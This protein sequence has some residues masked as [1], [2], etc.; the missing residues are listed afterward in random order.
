M[1]LI[2]QNLPVP[3]SSIRPR[4]YGGGKREDDL[5]IHLC[6]IVKANNRLKELMACAG[7]HPDIL[8][9]WT[10]LQQDITEYFDRNKNPVKQKQNLASVT[11]AGKN[12]TSIEERVRGKE[13]R[14][15]GNLMGKRIEKTARSV[16]SPDP[17][18][19]VDEVAIPLWWPRQTRIR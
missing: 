11:S 6:K 19:D 4:S 15:R 18:I 14:V 1:D 17:W 13:G 8:Q 3:P 5:T 2:L 16:I 12:R 10:I 9:N 7:N